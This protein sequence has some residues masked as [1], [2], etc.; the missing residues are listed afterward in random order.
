M[1]KIDVENSFHQYNAAAYNN[2]LL[3]TVHLI[4]CGECK[5]RQDVVFLG[6]L[7]LGKSDFGKAEQIEVFATQGPIEFLELEKVTPIIV[8]LA[9]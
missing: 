2:P 9:G 3:D 8:K 7:K 6:Y 1:Y 4:T 5:Y